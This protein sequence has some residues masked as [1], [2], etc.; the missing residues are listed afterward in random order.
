MKT[1]KFFQFSYANHYEP[2]FIKEESQHDTMLPYG[3]LFTY[4]TY[5]VGTSMSRNLPKSWKEKN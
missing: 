1:A 5:S 3:G 2:S 4:A